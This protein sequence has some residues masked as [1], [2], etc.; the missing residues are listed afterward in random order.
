MNYPMCNLLERVDYKLAQTVLQMCCVLL[1]S[2][3]RMSANC[4]VGLANKL[5]MMEASAQRHHTCRSKRKHSFRA[6]PVLMIYIHFDSMDAAPIAANLSQRRLA[7][8]RQ[9]QKKG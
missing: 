4:L 2:D 5:T 7:G 3:C 1:G 6:T 9:I 8:I